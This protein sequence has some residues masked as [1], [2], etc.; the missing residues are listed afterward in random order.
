MAIIVTG[1]TG[2]IG[3]NVVR[4]LLKTEDNVVCVIR[5]DSEAL[6]IGRA[7]V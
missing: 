3:N 5:K 6:Q 2:H 4:H 1:A 7:H